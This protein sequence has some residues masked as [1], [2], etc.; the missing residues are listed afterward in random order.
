M[1]CSIYNY[2]KRVGQLMTCEQVFNYQYNNF[3]WFTTSTSTMLLPSFLAIA[4][5][6]SV[7]F[8][9]IHFTFLMNLER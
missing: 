1:K 4:Y 6:P 5:T 7:P 2:V 9:K 8:Y 3:M